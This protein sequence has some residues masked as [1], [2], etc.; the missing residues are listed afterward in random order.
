MR[1]LCVMTMILRYTDL[2]VF[3]QTCFE[4]YW[5]HHY[6]A[7]VKYFHKSMPVELMFAYGELV[8]RKAGEHSNEYV[9]V[10]FTS[11]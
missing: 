10:Q 7:S 2:H 8:C 4:C 1:G 11:L 6:Y 9:Q 5:V 3:H